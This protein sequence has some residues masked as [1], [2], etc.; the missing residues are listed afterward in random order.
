[1][2]VDKGRS[3]KFAFLFLPIAFN[4]QS[5]V[6]GALLS[7]ETHDEIMGNVSQALVSLVDLTLDQTVKIID[8][9]QIVLNNSENVQGNHHGVILPKIE[10]DAADLRAGGQPRLLAGAGHHPAL[11]GRPRHPRQVQRQIDRHRLLN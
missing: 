11:P 6:T 5:E 10:S 1:M 4:N 2:F 7:D 8:W 9:L 3:K